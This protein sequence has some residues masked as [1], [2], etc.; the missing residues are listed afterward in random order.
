M[1]D[2]FNKQL[3]HV[4]KRYDDY[5]V[6]RYAQNGFQ[7]AAFESE[8]HTVFYY[9][10]QLEN[11]PVLLLIHGFGGDGKLTWM[12]QSFH[13]AKYYRVIVPD[14]L[15]FGNSFS[16]KEPSL[17]AQVDAF[18]GL[19]NHL[20]INR[21]HICGISYGGFVV[22]GMTHYYPNRIKSLN[23]VN[24]P[25]HVMPLSEVEVFCERNDVNDVSEIFVPQSGTELKRLFDL[26]FHVE[27]F[28]PKLFMSQLFVQYFATWKDEKIALLHELPENRADIKSHPE[29][30]SAIYW[31]E[32]DAIFDVKYAKEL[33]EELKAEVNTFTG[34]GHGLPAELPSKFNKALERFLRRIDAQVN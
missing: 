16:K 30:P 23:V 28:A 8:E 12:N 3:Q 9:D 14:L 32:S 17:K 13:F 5:L 19:M 11:A 26:T 15:W 27:P 34:A 7:S 20:E 10:N 33:G 25:G 2:F 21:A 6:Y 18:V 1:I 22:L 31:G 29:V 4:V 24:S